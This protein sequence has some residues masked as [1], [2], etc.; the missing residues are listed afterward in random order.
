[1]G[2]FLLKQTRASLDQLAQAHDIPLQT[3][4]NS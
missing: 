4:H 3:L 1:M 2:D